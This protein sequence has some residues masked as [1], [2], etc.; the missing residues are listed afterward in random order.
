[1]GVAL[2]TVTDSNIALS[3]MTSEPWKCCC[4]C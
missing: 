4:P 3:L 1:M 2:I